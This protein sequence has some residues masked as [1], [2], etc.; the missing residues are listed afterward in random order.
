MTY[1]DNE[2]I[3]PFKLKKMAE[4]TSKI[5]TMLP[6]N[7]AVVT[8]TCDDCMKILRWAGLMIEEGTH[9]EKHNA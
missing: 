2:N 5:V 7:T 1:T 4:M 8:L 3:P 6:G 9:V